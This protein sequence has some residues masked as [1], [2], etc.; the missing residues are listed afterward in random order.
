RS[1]LAV[2][3][4]LVDRGVAVY[5]DGAAALVRRVLE[6]VGG[7]VLTPDGPAV[8]ADASGDVAAPAGDRVGLCCAAIHVRAA[9]RHAV[10]AAGHGEGA[11]FALAM[12]R[13]DEADR[14]LAAASVD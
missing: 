1:L 10:A 5:L 3:E 11:L 6:I 13:S 12:G 2:V 8:M 14:H 7:P 4:D 9:T